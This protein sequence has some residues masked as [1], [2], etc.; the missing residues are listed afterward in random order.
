MHHKLN[1]GFRH[2]I[3]H[4][5]IIVSIR[6]EL[7]A[8]EGTYTVKFHSHYVTIPKVK[9]T[10]NK[11]LTRGKVTLSNRVKVDKALEAVNLNPALLNF[12]VTKKFVSDDGNR[13]E[14][15]IEDYQSVCK[16]LVFNSLD[17]MREFV[18]KA[19]DYKLWIGCRD[20][21]P[22]TSMVLCG[23]TGSG[24][25][26]ANYFLCLQLLCWKQR[27]KL[28][29]ADCK[30]GGLSVAGSIIAP[31]RTAVEI[32]DVITLIEQFHAELQQRKYALQ[33]K[34]KDHLD[35]DY[36][37]FGYPPNVLVFEEY[38]AFVGNLNK[39]EAEKVTKILRDGILLGRQ[40]GFFL[41]IVMQKS[42]AST[43]PTQ[44][45]D[46]LPLKVCLGNSPETT[47]VT[48]FERKPEIAVRR[49]GPGQGIYTLHESEPILAAFPKLN[50]DIAEAFHKLAESDK[51][52]AVL[53]PGA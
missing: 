15:D 48:L 3:L 2:A 22:L 53:P 20:T 9:L 5:K 32:P 34:L 28:Y 35:G 41:W 6:K 26:Y 39:K 42:D 46:N 31:E 40:L 18:E 16:Q 4:T 44:L 30:A 47:Y 45:R 1:Y 7:L 24:K 27:P 29:F 50:F 14:Y 12:V 51:T 37:E 19:E 49:F 23:V 8:S 43:L 21:V 11:D 17:E 52:A 13:W 36:T 25:S 38:A 10:F 33:G